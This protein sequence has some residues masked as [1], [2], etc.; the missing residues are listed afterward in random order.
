V[1]LATFNVENLFQRAKA[2][3]LTTWAEGRPVLDAWNRFNRTANK[4]TYTAADRTRMLTDLQTLGVLVVTASGALR[5]NKRF[6][7]PA[8][9]A[10][11][12]ENR[13]DF[14]K[15]PRSGD[16]EI[17]ATGRDAWLGWVDLLVES[18]DQTATR[19]T[20][21]VI[22][23]V[24]ADVLAVVEAESR[25]ALVRFNAD[26]LGTRYRHA[27]CI[28]GNDDRGIDVGVYTSDGFPV[29]IVSH[30]D[31]VD[32]SGIIFSRDCPEFTIE[33]PGSAPILVLVNHFK[34][35]G[36][37]TQED[38][39]KKRLR[40][41]TRVRQIY[42]QRRAQGID[43]VAIVG[44]L[45]DTP[46]SAPLVPLVADGSDLRDVMDHPDFVSDGRPGTFGNGTAS[47][48]IDYV[49]LSPSLWGD[50]QQ[51]GIL[52][53]GVWGGKNGTLFPHYPEI[54]EAKHAASDHA[55]LWVD[56]A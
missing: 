3:D 39:D 18:V 42:D 38:S 11:L 13:G 1:R 40:Q 49:L 21:R 31:D 24:A 30:V 17:V 5:F 33:R 55:A 50:V 16:V 26:L 15:E 34:S 51:A 41:A 46:A 53:D 8:R 44:D 37:G 4:V 12:R 20:A 27:M 45:N 9:W 10:V 47:Q 22:S 6:D 19:M 35:K 2:L 7:D 25:T 56:L 28:D 14:V 36:F 54:T 48:K 43:R 23:D 32:A 52:R 29:S